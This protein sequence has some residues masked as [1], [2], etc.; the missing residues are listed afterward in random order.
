MNRKSLTKGVAMKKLHFDDLVV[1]QYL[2]TPRL[3]GIK[4]SVSPYTGETI[5][6]PIPDGTLP[7]FI[8]R[9][10]S[11]D[12]PYVALLPV[13]H[14]LS[15]DFIPKIMFLTLEGRDWFVVS[16]EFVGTLLK[17]QNKA[18]EPPSQAN[19]VWGNSIISPVGKDGPCG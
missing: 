9:V 17:Y 4:K 7:E 5:E 15:Y 6:S 12:V 10:E 13:A 2:I 18:A 16:S 14:Q 11:F 1:G 19:P 3:K 8:F